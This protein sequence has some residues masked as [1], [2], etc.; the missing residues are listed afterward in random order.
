[1]FVD[2]KAKLARFCAILYY[3]VT[4]KLQQIIL[5]ISQPSQYRYAKLQYKFGIISGSSSSLYHYSYFQCVSNLFYLIRYCVASRDIE[6]CELILREEAAAAGPYTKTNPV[7]LQCFKK[8]V[9]LYVQKFLS[10]FKQ[11]VTI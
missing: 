8:V 3:R 5:Q 4:Q 7:C 10:I 2:W 11:H 9:I 1:M 6:P